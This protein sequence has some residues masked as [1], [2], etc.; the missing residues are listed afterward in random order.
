[1]TSSK[2]SLVTLGFLLIL[3]GLASADAIIT[4][5]TLHIPERNGADG[6]VSKK[7][8][9]D[10]VAVTLAQGFAVT[11]TS[12]TFLLTTILPPG[13]TLSSRTLLQNDDRVG[14][15]AW[16]DSPDV[17]RTLRILREHLRSSFSKELQNLID[18]TQSEAGKPPRDILSFRDP[19]ILGERVVFA[20]VRERL[21][22]FHVTA[23]KE[24]SI[25]GLLNALTE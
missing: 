23:G 10:V 16:I 4:R 14:A 2:K 18:E 9:P 3:I 15:L 5:G 8:G 13:T 22:E 19:A 24:A 6:G 11:D 20:R 7:P 1:M 25:D 21:Y 12:D 17:K